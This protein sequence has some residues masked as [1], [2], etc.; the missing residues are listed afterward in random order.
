MGG[1]YLYLSQSEGL[2]LSPKQVFV[3]YERQPTIHMKRFWMSSAKV[4]ASAAKLELSAPL[5]CPNKAKLQTHD[6][7]VDWIVE[8]ARTRLD[9]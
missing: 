4:I 3:Q 1:L 8:T 7:M 6:W 5:R 9:S 2:R